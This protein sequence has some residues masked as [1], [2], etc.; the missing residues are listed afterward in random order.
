MIFLALN[1]VYYWRYKSNAH[2]HYNLLIKTKLN[3]VWKFFTKVIKGPSKV[4]LGV[5]RQ[6]IFIKREVQALLLLCKTG[7]LKSEAQVLVFRGES[8]KCFLEVII[9]NW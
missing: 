4:D 5:N 8:R 2:K 7:C 9:D 6:S 3:K 1:G